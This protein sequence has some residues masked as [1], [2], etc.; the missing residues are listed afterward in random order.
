M[1]ITNIN[2]FSIN[3]LKQF[4]ASHFLTGQ[5]AQRQ[6]FDAAAAGLFSGSTLAETLS[7]GLADG[8]ITVPTSVSELKSGNIIFWEDNDNETQVGVVLPD[9]ARALHLNPAT[10]DYESVSLN[11]LNLKGRVVVQ[12]WIS[13]NAPDIINP[14]VTMNYDIS[15][16]PYRAIRGNVQTGQLTGIIIIME[17]TGV[18]WSGGSSL[19]AYAN[20][21]RQNI[22][23]YWEQQTT[24]TETGAVPNS[25]RVNTAGVQPIASKADF[26]G[27]F[28]SPNSGLLSE[29][30]FFVY[31]DT[32][33]PLSPSDIANT[34]YSDRI[35]LI[36]VGNGGAGTTISG[37]T[38]GVVTTGYM[39]LSSNAGEAAHEF[40][41]LCGL[42]DR[43]AEAVLYDDAFR[44]SQ[45]NTFDFINPIR[46]SQS[47]LQRGLA[48]AFI[49][50]RTDLNQAV[51]SVP[52]NNIANLAMIT[53]GA[54]FANYRRPERVTIPIIIQEPD[55]DYRT[56]IM[57]KSEAS[58]GSTLSNF[59]LSVVFNNIGEITPFRVD[60][61]IPRSDL[62]LFD[63][64]EFVISDTTPSPNIVVRQ[65]VFSNMIPWRNRSRLNPQN[66][67]TTRFDQWF[68]VHDR[69][70]LPA[71]QFRY[72]PFLPG[73]VAPGELPPF[74]ATQPENLTS[75]VVFVL[76]RWMGG[77]PV[78]NNM[79]N[80]NI[81]ISTIDLFHRQTSLTTQPMTA[82]DFWCHPIHSNN[83]SQVANGQRWVPA[84]IMSHAVCFMIVNGLT[85]R[86]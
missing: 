58:V 69:S 36:T 80:G 6:Q 10:T 52:S 72:V 47:G 12:G 64:I 20:A 75:G 24:P 13:E 76:G 34:F 29:V 73:T 21:F 45:Q 38:R 32:A 82:Y 79:L 71:H 43:Y 77:L 31:T 65:V 83:L 54:V 11:G 41:H 4:S 23:N 26:L 5:Q 14:A 74:V 50:T 66:V 25:L 1:S 22:V 60:L 78:N 8:R 51:P 48:D 18:T 28:A 19:T 33:N 15:V 49:P 46:V 27:R 2:T 42:A 84:D 86:L 62:N 70:T 35:A 61:Y 53:A 7:N 30:D 57:S 44:L 3:Y 55:Y 63:G 16:N 37:I 9:L 39:M 81:G 56:N 40:G 85:S 68:K 59:Q 17:D 67:S